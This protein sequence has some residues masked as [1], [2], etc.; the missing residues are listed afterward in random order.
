VLLTV[1]VMDT[2]RAHIADAST[3]TKVII[4]FIANCGFAAKL[5]KKTSGELFVPI[6]FSETGQYETFLKT[7]EMKCLALHSLFA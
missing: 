6:I 1:S 7:K 4:F 3:M 2:A 5:R